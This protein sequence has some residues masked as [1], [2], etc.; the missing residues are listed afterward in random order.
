MSPP[1]F[2][3]V[4]YS[5]TLLCTRKQH[6]VS[7]EPFRYWPTATIQLVG[8]HFQLDGHLSVIIVRPHLRIL[9]GWNL[10]RQENKK[11]ELKKKVFLFFSKKDLRLCVSS[12]FFFLCFCWRRKCRHFFFY[13]GSVT[14]QTLIF[15]VWCGKRPTRV[16]HQGDSAQKQK[17][18]TIH[19]S[20]NA[21]KD[22]HFL[23]LFLRKNRIS[24]YFTHPAP[25][26]QERS[27]NSNVWSICV[28][29][30]VV[31]ESG[32]ARNVFLFF[33]S[34]SHS[35]IVKVFCIYINFNLLFY[36]Y[37]VCVSPFSFGCSSWKEKKKNSFWR[38][39]ALCTMNNIFFFPSLFCVWG[40]RPQR[41]DGRNVSN[42]KKEEDS[43]SFL[44][45]R[46]VDSTQKKSFLLFCVCIFWQWLP[47]YYH[48]ARIDREKQ[49][50]TINWD[51]R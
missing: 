45:F 34:E 24:P 12:F 5:R 37:L 49:N 13:S 40:G 25:P 48:H 18:H 30:A 36:L 32:P 33:Y 21:M 11:F 31:K 50:V 20:I 17:T 28:W 7:Q 6:T 42:E 27:M 9:K 38:R 23:F 15:S 29:Q 43:T 19:P 22:I 41:D 51:R 39:D 26:L 46:L 3:C 4:I 14:Y 35:I 2:Y 16:L 44:A 47:N 8:W 1:N 10:S